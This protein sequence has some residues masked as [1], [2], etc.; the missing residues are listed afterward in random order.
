MKKLE[1][2]KGEKMTY[3]DQNDKYDINVFNS[4]F[5]E[6]DISKM[7][8]AITSFGQITSPNQTLDVLGGI[9]Q[10]KAIYCACQIDE[11][12]VSPFSVPVELFKSGVKISE[13]V[14]NEQFYTVWYENTKVK[15]WYETMPDHTTLIYVY[16]IK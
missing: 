16:G 1:S 5:R 4:N 15:C 2:Y 8:G 12:I 10:Y 14:G 13:Y 6:L 3:P 7:S 9:D 11:Q